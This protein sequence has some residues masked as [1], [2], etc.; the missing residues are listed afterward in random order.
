MKSSVER[1]AQHTSLLLESSFPGEST[2]CL[3]GETSSPFLQSRC[4]QVVVSEGLQVRWAELENVLWIFA[5]HHQRIRVTEL[6][7]WK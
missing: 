4:R 7:L 2:G 5:R 3:C 1:E 6:F